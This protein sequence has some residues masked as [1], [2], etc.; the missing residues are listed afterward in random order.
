[1]GI[2]AGAGLIRI[3]WRRCS[4]CGGWVRANNGDGNSRSL[5]DDKQKDKQQQEQRQ[6]LNTGILHFVQDDDGGG[7]IKSTVMRDPSLCDLLR[8]RMTT[9]LGSDGAE[10]LERSGLWMH[11][12]M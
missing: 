6:R 1:M 11:F 10:V 4:R 8:V 2:S 5:R 9:F 12:G 3:L 7:V